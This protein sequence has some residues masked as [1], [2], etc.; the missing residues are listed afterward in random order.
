MQGSNLWCDQKKKGV[1]SSFAKMIRTR[2]A[3]L[4]RKVFKARWKKSRKK[5][6]NIEELFLFVC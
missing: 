5:I 2:K 1:K 4:N 6:V 3:Q